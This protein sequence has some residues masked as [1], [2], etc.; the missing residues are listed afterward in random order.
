MI[1]ALA[2]IGAFTLAVYAYRII[3]I[4]R[5]YRDAPRFPQALNGIRGIHQ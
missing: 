5:S 4:I 2:F 1:D 3:R